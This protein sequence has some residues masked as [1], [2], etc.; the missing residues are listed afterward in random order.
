MPIA[1]LEELAEELKSD[2]ARIWIFD[3]TWVVLPLALLFAFDIAYRAYA[4]AIADADVN[5]LLYEAILLVAVAGALVIAGKKLTGAWRMPQ[6]FAWL[7]IAGPLWLAVFTPIGAALEM[8]AQQPQ[9]L[10]VW[11]G[12]SLFVAINEEVIFRGFVLKGL[13]RKSGTVTAVLLSSFAFGL[14]HLLNL[15]EGGEPVLIGAQIISAMGI[16]AV[17]AAVTLRSGSLWPAI[18]LHFLADVI[19]L[20]ALGGYGE[21]IQT[22]ELAPAVAISGAVFLAWGTF[23]A[24]R[25]SRAGKIAY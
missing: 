16:G 2:K 7:W 19:G 22:V 3:L 14:L 1:E 13:L 25:I 8:I 6:G 21:A 20:A 4:P 9:K 23:W 15:L 18:V 10:I 12:V 5:L 11:V 17:L 24:W